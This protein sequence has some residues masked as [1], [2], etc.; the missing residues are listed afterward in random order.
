MRLG[1]RA[2]LFLLIAAVF[3]LPFLIGWNLLISRTRSELETMWESALLSHA[4]ALR[5]MIETTERSSDSLDALIAR[6]V[7][8]YPAHVTVFDGAGELLSDS[9]FPDKEESE[10][11]TDNGEL[12]ETVFGSVNR[13]QHYNAILR[14]DIDYLSLPFQYEGGQ[15]VV[16]IGKPLPGTNPILGG[17][18]LS[19]LVLSGLG[20]AVLV[21]VAARYLM[22][23]RFK[24]LIDSAEA[25]AE[26]RENMSQFRGILSGKVLGELAEAL[27]LTVRGLKKL[28]GETAEE[29]DRFEAVLEDM[30]EGVLALDDNRRITHVNPAAL[31][32]LN[33]SNPPIGQTLLEVIRSPDLD[34]LVSKPHLSKVIEFD[35]D[36]PRR[37]FE[38]GDFGTENHRRLSARVTPRRTSGGVV[39]VIHDV[40]ELRRLEVVRRDFIANVSHELR[41]PVSIIRANAETLLEDS[42]ELSSRN[43]SFLE[44]LQRNSER[45]SNIIADLLDLS[46]IESGQYSL[47]ITA[48][49]I[50]EA[51]HRVVQTMQ[52]RTEAR[53]VVL[54]MDLEPRLF[55][56]ADRKA[57]DQVLLNLVK[58]A[59]IHTPESSH[60]L[61][62]S[63]LVDN[64]VRIEV[65]DDGPGIELKHHERI[66]ERF[67]RVDT[68][69]AGGGTGLGLSI[70]RNLIDAMGGQVGLNYADPHGSIFW[71]KLP[72]RA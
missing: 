17:F 24:A 37:R 45:L 40:T 47:E 1:L 20:A 25:I 64:E 30:G 15:G 5:A 28:S 33:L 66:F 63:F 46:R 58:N 9:P 35:V 53:Q 32:L 31:E 62:R 57:L 54:E 23:N 27:N 59:I 42:S 7:E 68:G 60:V 56:L 22:L 16:R 41:T 29:R 12:P 52:N 36:A 48:I 4:M 70:V 6:F 13:F 69:R 26:G 3:L 65:C 67:Y 18:R 43:Q 55:V 14:A 21:S 49:P 38:V 71:V 50:E 34:V 11:N 39:L 8:D 19:L 10:G 2:K 44:A 61:L 72:I 51:I